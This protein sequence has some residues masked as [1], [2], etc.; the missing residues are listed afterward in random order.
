[1]IRRLFL[2]VTAAVALILTPTLAMAHDAPHFTCKVSDSTP[3][4]GQTVKVSCTGGHAREKITLTIPG[5]KSLTTQLN[6]K[7][8]GSFTFK[9]T[10]AGV[11]KLKIT[12]AKGAVLFTATL[13]V[14]QGYHAPGYACT[15]SDSTPAIGQDFNVSCSGGQALESITQTITSSPGSIS[16]QDIQ[17]A[18]TKSL[19]SRLSATGEGTITNTLAVAGVYTLT[20]TSASGA[21]GSTQVVTVAA[22]SARPSAAALSPLSST[23]FD[24][25]GLAV[26]GGELL[27]AGACA[28]LVARR[29]KSAQVPA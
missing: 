10:K 5:T 11:Y 6:S 24:G 23:G 4:V 26:G 22:A 16:N 29:R 15:L 2:A 1:M 19:T 18:G 14:G 8:E 13:R 12:N 25:H 20:M 3:A 7:G 9:L 21:V 17:T 27:L 28:A